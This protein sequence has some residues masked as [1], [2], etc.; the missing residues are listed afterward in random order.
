MNSFTSLSP[1]R[2][3][4]LSLTSTLFDGVPRRVLRNQHSFADDSPCHHPGGIE[5]L[6]RVGPSMGPQDIIQ[7]TY[8]A[9]SG[10]LTPQWINTDGCMVLVLVDIDCRSHAF[11]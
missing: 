10:T 1:P 3:S 8:D 11:V 5:A 6:H 9:T 2:Y 4:I 7:W